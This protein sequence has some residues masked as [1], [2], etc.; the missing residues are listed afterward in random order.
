VHLL[1]VPGAVQAGAAKLLYEQLERDA[2]ALGATELWCRDTN[3]HMDV[4]DYLLGAGFSELYRVHEWHVDIGAWLVREPG[5]VGKGV[6][7]TTLADEQGNPDRV[8]ELH[9]F[10]NAPGSKTS[11]DEAFSLQEVEARLSSAHVVPESYF[12]AREEG[13]IVGVLVVRRPHAATKSTAD[14][15]WRVLD[16]ALDG[17]IEARLM[18]AAVEYG[19]AH[20][21]RVFTAYFRGEFNDATYLRGMGLLPSVELVVLAKTVNPTRPRLRRAALSVSTERVTGSASP[22]K[23]GGLGLRVVG[24]GK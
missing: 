16:K 21:Y 2:A 20:A 3:E 12:I 24:R 9:A 7:M 17:A 19:R 13:R 22:R 14:L 18:G 23:R 10:W 15:H 1:A 5:P 11:P 4:V 8:R 6:T